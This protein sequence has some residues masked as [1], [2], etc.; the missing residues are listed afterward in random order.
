[1]Q[2]LPPALPQG[3]ARGPG[4]WRDALRGWR[5]RLIASPRFQRFAARFPL[6][7]SISARKARALFDLATG[8]VHSQVLAACVE[9]D[10]FERLADRPMTAAELAAACR[11]PPDAALRLLRAAASLDLT[12]ERGEDRFGL[13]DLGAALRGNPGVAAMIRHHAMLYD[14]LRDPVALL[15]G[16]GRPT[17]LQRYWAYAGAADRDDASGRPGEAGPAD[18]Q[19]ARYT[20]LMAASQQLVAADIL[21]AWPV[22]RHRRI[23][24]VG[25]GDG[26]FLRAVA[27]RAPEAELVLFDLPAVAARAARA[28][29]RIACVGGDFT[30]EPL[31]SGADLI[32]L[33]RIGHDH[34]DPVLR[35]LFAR[36]FEALA[37]G[38]VLL[39]GEPMAGQRGAEAMADAYFG[40]YF[41]AMGQGR[42]R[43]PAEIAAMLSEAGFVEARQRPTPRPLL[44]CVMTARKPI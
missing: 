37:P 38:G 21:D 26:S 44:T 22:A 12:E 8:F 10:L 9:L 23:M 3:A 40:F 42:A 43:R 34:D 6:T 29:G 19:V 31:P 18:A 25:G 32:T 20:T 13:G 35:R 28:G 41:L 14:D 7:R 1:M 39:I 27:E 4:R 16:E 33:V 2:A 30:R 36:V 5:H 15:R 17:E 11:L 24:D